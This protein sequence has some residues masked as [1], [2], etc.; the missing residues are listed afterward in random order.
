LGPP[1]E[2]FKILIN[3]RVDFLSEMKG[4]GKAQINRHKDKILLD[5]MGFVI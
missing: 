4:L 5:L 2:I 3:L 1:D